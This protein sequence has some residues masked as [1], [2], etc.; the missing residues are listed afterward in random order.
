MPSIVYKREY[1]DKADWRD[2]FVSVEL[3]YPDFQ[4]KLLST[5]KSLS[6]SEMRAL[7]LMCAGLDDG[8]I[9]E[10][11]SVARS[12]VWRWRNDYNEL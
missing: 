2:L 9:V 10:L 8:Q 3:L 1:I 7:Y 12:T 6:E 5:K 4:S 11:L